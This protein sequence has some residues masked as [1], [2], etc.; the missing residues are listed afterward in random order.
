[1]S[2]VEK[3]IVT[4]TGSVVLH[5]SIFLNKMGKPYSK[6]V[7]VQKHELELFCTQLTNTHTH[8]HKHFILITYLLFDRKI[9]ILLHDSHILF[10]QNLITLSMKGL[11]LKQMFMWT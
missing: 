10:S 1:V 8:T 4:D 5:S 11:Y 6:E 9:Y 2:N 7:A 3:Q